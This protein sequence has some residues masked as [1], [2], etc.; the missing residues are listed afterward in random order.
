MLEDLRAL[1]SRFR[2]EELDTFALSYHMVA[3]ADG[4]ASGKDLLGK[5]HDEIRHLLVLACAGEAAPFDQPRTVDIIGGPA[6]PRNISG[7]T[8]EVSA[9]SCLGQRRPRIVVS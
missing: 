2:R 9:R 3:R 5:G 8:S 7:C 6:R 1:Q 4:I